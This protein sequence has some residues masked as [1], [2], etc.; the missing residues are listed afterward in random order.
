VNIPVRCTFKN[1]GKRQLLQTFRG[2]AAVAEV[3][4][5]KVSPLQR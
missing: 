4:G 1:L 2:A 5:L 3:C